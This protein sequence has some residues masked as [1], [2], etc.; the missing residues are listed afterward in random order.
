MAHELAARGRRVLIADYSDNPGGGGYGTTTALL[1]ALLDRPGPRVVFAP[2]C[3]ERAA[4]LCAKAGAGSNITLTV[5]TDPEG[6]FSGPALELSGKVVRC[7]DVQFRAT[8]PMWTNRE[9]RLGL[10][11]L[12]SC[13]PVDIVITSYPLQV[14]D[15]AYLVAAG[16]DFERAQIIAIKSMQ[17]FRAAFEPL[18]DDILFADSGGIVSTR[19]ERFP[20]RNVRRPIWPLDADA[21]RQ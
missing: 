1:A 10:T 21:V 6:A 9:M 18:V 15:P 2:L 14:T 12:V 3:D 16:A 8:G 7:G 20:Y 13:G 5:G 19:L 4:A 11:A 17:H